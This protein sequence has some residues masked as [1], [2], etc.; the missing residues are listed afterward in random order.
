MQELRHGQANDVDPMYGPAV[1][2]S[3]QPGGERSCINV[4][5]LRLERRHHGLAHRVV[6]PAAALRVAEAV[7]RPTMKFVATKTADQFDLQALH[8]VR[9]RLVGQRTGIINQIRAF[10]LERGIAV[11]QG[12]HFLRAELPPILAKRS[13]AC[14]VIAEVV[15]L[16]SRVGPHIFGRHQPSV[17]TKQCA[18]RKRP[19]Q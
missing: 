9:E 6:S 2:S 10:L 13:P 15:L 19:C 1:R 16:P 14:P 5:D 11:R 17:V 12:L 7:Q 18:H 4:S 3:R 8:R